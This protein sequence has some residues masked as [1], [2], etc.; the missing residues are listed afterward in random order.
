MF[1]LLDMAERVR[2]W[3]AGLVSGVSLG[4]LR[5]RVRG[6]G[7]GLGEALW[8]WLPG[9]VRQKL[10]WLEGKLV[11]ILMAPVLA[12]LV[13]LMVFV[14]G[15]PGGSASERPVPGS[16]A[17][18]FNPAPI[19]PE[20]LF[21]PEEPDFLPPVIL[22]RERRE[23]WTAEDAEPFWYDPLE[24]SKEEWRDLVEE[25]VDDLLERVP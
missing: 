4:A 15:L 12:L 9:G 21:L 22:G 14:A 11:F 7:R 2:E 10:P 20:D 5:D 1:P 25:L 17:G 24:D 23:A 6:A 8:V 19:P 18:I 3:A 13:A 16:S